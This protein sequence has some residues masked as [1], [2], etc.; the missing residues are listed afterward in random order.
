MS[1]NAAKKVKPLTKGMTEIL[2]DCHEREL[3]KL[4]PYTVRDIKFAK[5]LIERGLIK[6]ETVTTDKGK[7]I[8]AFYVTVLA[9]N[10]LNNL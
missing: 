3:L 2:M 9:R 7:T 8:V 4:E 1:K 10:Y 5:G 6:P